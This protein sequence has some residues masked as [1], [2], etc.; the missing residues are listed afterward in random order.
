[1]FC[2]WRAVCAIWG[3]SPS[4]RSR[5]HVFWSVSSSIVLRLVD[6][7]SGDAVD[8]SHERK[9]EKEEA[10]G[11]GDGALRDA[12]R[13]DASP[14]DGEARADEVP[15]DGAERDGVR[16]EVRGERDGGDLRAVPPLR[17]KGEDE[18]LEEDWGEEAA[19]DATHAAFGRAAPALEARLLLLELARE[20][21]VRSLP[22]DVH[23]P[24][25][26]A[27]V[28]HERQ[29]FTTARDIRLGTT[30]P[31][32]VDNT[33]I[34]T[35]APHAPPSTTNRGCRIAITAAMMNVSSPNSLTRIIEKEDTNECTS[36][37]SSP[38]ALASAGSSGRAAA[39]IASSA[40]AHAR[41]RAARA[42]SRIAT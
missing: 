8:E 20:L 42:L 32:N 17:E 2:P 37:V 30:T 29:A 5:V 41:A 3:V 25:P 16:V 19:Q 21:R 13:E 27:R 23:Q 34:T 33:V 40:P 6:V 12:E 28:E 1:M 18:R 38:P 36:P 4:A 35:S 39:T 15:D 11:E 31:S 22:R 9:D 7:G 26:E 24:N 10:A 14:E